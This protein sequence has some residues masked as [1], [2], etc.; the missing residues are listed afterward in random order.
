MAELPNLPAHIAMLSQAVLDEVLW[1]PQ[2][3]ADGLIV[4]AHR[5]HDVHKRYAEAMRKA[6]QVAGSVCAAPRG[7]AMP[8]AAARRAGPRAAA[9]LNHAQAPLVKGHQAAAH[10]ARLSA[11]I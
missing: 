3:P 9:F 11:H 7:A 10:A 5:L 4:S 8:R 2:L 1:W 6:A